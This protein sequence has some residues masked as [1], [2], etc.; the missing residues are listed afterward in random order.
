MIRGYR[1]AP[2]DR[3]ALD[4]IAAAVRAG[5]TAG[6]SQGVSVVVITDPAV[7]AAVAAL[8]GEN[9]YVG[10]GFGP[11]LSSAPA[12][13]LICV[14]PEVYRARYAEP[15]KDPAALAVP[16]WWVDGG[17]ALG[18]ILLAAV[19]EGYAAG[20]LGVHRLGDIGGLL[21]IPDDVVVLGLVT[22]GVPSEGRRSS[23][24][25]RPRRRRLHRE[26]WEG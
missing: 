4:R 2:V 8:A 24:L 21:G 18:L 5:P 10:R 20:F 14:E 19:D 16:W 11:W 13:L 22:V 23:S 9:D 12:H 25:D 6:N 15:D 1:P 7:R 3:D 17:A 26:R